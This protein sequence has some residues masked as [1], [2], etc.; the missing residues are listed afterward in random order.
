[1]RKINK[2]KFFRSISITVGVLIF[3]IL[4]LTNISF[5]STEITYKNIIVS[6]GDTLWSIAKH[7][8]DNNTYFLDKDIRDI[9]YEIKSVN[10]L[11]TSN[12]NIGDKLTIPTI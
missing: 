10:D 5:S 11:N 2:M 1:M 4:T 12:L 6:S 8:K 9:V 3:F 7:E